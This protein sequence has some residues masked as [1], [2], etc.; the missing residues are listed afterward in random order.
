MAG[1]QQVNADI[2]LLTE[3]RYVAASAAEDD[4]YLRNIL[5]EDQLLQTALA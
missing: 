2:A 1:L 4:W 3:R 5:Q